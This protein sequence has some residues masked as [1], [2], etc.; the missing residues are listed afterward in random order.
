MQ[1]NEVAKL[2]VFINSIDARVVPEDSKIMAWDKVLNPHMPYDMAV[3][4]ASTH[5]RNSKDSIMP[6]DI[7]LMH[8]NARNIPKFD[9]GAIEAPN[10][11]VDHEWRKIVTADLKAKIKLSTG[12]EYAQGG[13]EWE[14]EPGTGQYAARAGVDVFAEDELRPENAEIGFIIEDE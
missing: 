11:V 7:N 10:T 2:L 9:M 14:F 3:E 6:S 8:R 4:Y 13:L 5:Y 12:I 1:T